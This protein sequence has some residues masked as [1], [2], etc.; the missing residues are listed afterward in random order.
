MRRFSITR[1][2]VY[3]VLANWLLFALIHGKIER[4]GTPLDGD[5]AHPPV[6]QMVYPP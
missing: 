4:A 3:A 2:L 5:L 1:A 6:R